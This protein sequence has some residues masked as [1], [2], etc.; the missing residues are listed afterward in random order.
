[1]Q[2]FGNLTFLAKLGQKSKLKRRLTLRVRESSNC[3]LLTVASF[4]L[5][6]VFFSSCG[7]V[8]SSSVG[9]SGTT[10]PPGTTSG[11]PTLTSGSFAFLVGGLDSQKHTIAIG[12]SVALDA[13]GNVTGGEQDYVSHGG[14]MSPPSGDKI[15]GGK[16]TTT[17]SGNG[18]LTLITNN[19]AI[20][21][22]GTETFSIAIVNSKH[23]VIA[24]FDGGATSRGTMDMQT[25]SSSGGLAQINGPYSFTVSGRHGNQI[26]EMF[27]GS[28]TADGAGGLKTKVDQNASGV[29]THGANTGTYTAP[30]GAG[31]GTMSFGGD[32]VSYYVVN[33][34]VIRL[35]VTTVGNPHL[36]SAYAGVTGVT[37]AVLN[38]KFVF[39]ASSNLSADPVYSA[40]GLIT[41]DGNGHVSGF[42]DVDENGH[43]TSAPFTGTYTVD[44]NGFGSITIT[45]GNTQ[46]ISVL[47]L[48]LTDPT[49]NFSD[50]NSPA[51]P[52]DAGL[53]G[54]LLDLD[55][56]IPGTGVLILP[57]GG[58]NAPTANFAL[59]IQSV[60]T[61]NE[62]NAV[63][64]VKISGSSVSGTEDINDLFKTLSSAGQNAGISVSGT[65]VADTTNAGRF[66]LPL[67]VT[68][69]TTPPTFNYVLYQ[70]SNTQIIA[71]EVDSPQY[72]LGMLEQQH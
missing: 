3:G 8:S 37:N 29:V 60:N 47:G 36:G 72:G 69:G 20:G 15:T 34:K 10:T 31:R 32:S 61:S 22:G 65:L 18:T 51:G 58:V 50:P 33:P 28:I 24:E 30:D 46:D 53:C 52:A 57:G 55:P 62:A 11:G 48:Y 44:S 5:L 13:S 63:G 41:A 12:G 25:L 64:V 59:S 14:A 39:T 43:A 2:L 21:V 4:L 54:L 67:G 1:M 23:A 66:T 35:V 42:A 7:S 45:P 6:A 70:A 68:I 16:L 26:I 71:L 38:T 27:G 19:T 56:K 49:I 17:A 9:T 40:A